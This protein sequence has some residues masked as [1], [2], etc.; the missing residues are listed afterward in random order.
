MS[1]EYPDRGISLSWNMGF[2]IGD[3]EGEYGPTPQ[4]E[5]KGA[6]ALAASPF[7]HSCQLIV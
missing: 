2:L 4:T 7:S 1:Y 6:A 3:A 5:R